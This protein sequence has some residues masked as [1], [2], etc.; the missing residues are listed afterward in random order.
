[1][2]LFHLKKRHSGNQPPRHGVFHHL[3]QDADVDWSFIFVV[4][5]LVAIVCVTLGVRIY[6]GLDARLL[7]PLGKAGSSLSLFDD[8]ALSKVIKQFDDNAAERNN[9]LEQYSGPGDPSL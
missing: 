7:G 9:I 4:F 1:M 2:K 5:I 3:S 6:L 8:K